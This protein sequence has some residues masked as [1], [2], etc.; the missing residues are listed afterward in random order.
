MI[1]IKA[2]KRLITSQ[3]SISLEV[4]FKIADKELIALYGPSG[5]GKTTILRMIAGLTDPDEGF[6]KVDDE[7]WFDSGKGINKPVQ[8]RRISY[9]FQDYNL[10]PHMTVRENLEYALQNPKDYNLIDDALEMVHLTALSHCK[11]D[12]L[13]GGQK[14]RVALIRAL[15][16]KPKIFLLDEPL[17]SLDLE[18]RL[19]LQDE[20]LAIYH[21]FKIPT[22]FVTHDLSE[23]FKLSNQI[24]ILEQGKIVRAGKPEEIFGQ[25]ILSGEFKFVGNIL[26]LKL[27]DFLYIVTVQ[28]GHNCTKVIATEEEAR[29]WRVGD[30]VLVAAKAFNPII[31]KV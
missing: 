1:I 25:E 24:L 27:E 4:D 20:I 12:K 28:I 17:S 30:K 19:K 11:P 16:H 26:E 31:M 6:I 22:I 3:G 29:E 5:A 21:R 18:L 15:L 7:V 8:K 10:F 23:V 2:K 14:Q 13:S 9:V